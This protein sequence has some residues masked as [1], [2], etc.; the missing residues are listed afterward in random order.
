MSNHH[1]LSLAGIIAAIDTLT[2]QEG[3]INVLV[4]N[5][6]ALLQFLVPN[7]ASILLNNNNGAERG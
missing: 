2:T 3:S 5:K 4:H 7:M 1:E 6:P